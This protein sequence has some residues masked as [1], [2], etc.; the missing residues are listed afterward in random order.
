[1]I[2]LALNNLTYLLHSDGS[3][4]KI[5]DPCR[6]GSIFCGSGR[7]WFGFE[8]WKFPLKISNFSIFFPSGK[9]NLFGSGQKVSW[10]KP[11]RPLIYCG[12]KVSSGRVGSG[13]IST[14][15]S[16]FISRIRSYAP[17]F[18]NQLLIL[19]T[20]SLQW[21]LKQCK[22]LKFSFAKI[23]SLRWIKEGDFLNPEILFLSHLSL[24]TGFLA[25]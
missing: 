6:V 23:F 14:F 17:W 8:F 22:I 2:R 13:A 20:F 12:S 1:M 4:S 11:S 7:V 21:P 3:G 5:F 19:M 15:A 18:L 24:L 16:Q 9:K 25:F 10:S